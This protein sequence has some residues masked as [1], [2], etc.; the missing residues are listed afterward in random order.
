MNTTKTIL[1]GTDGKT[2]YTLTYDGVGL[3]YNEYKDVFSY[4]EG[5][6]RAIDSLKDDPYFWKEAVA[7]DSTTASLE[8][9]AEDCV[10]I[11]GWRHI[12]GED[13]IIEVDDR[14]NY[15]VEEYNHEEGEGLP[16][17]ESM[18]YDWLN[19]EI[20]DFDKLKKGIENDDKKLFEEVFAKYGEFDGKELEG[21]I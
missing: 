14:E 18:Y 5:E 11:D 16:F 21:R 9:W 15:F 2:V 12:L 6:E 7:S 3:E 17:D 13:N 4:D 8:E 20:E 1:L 19:I 10:N